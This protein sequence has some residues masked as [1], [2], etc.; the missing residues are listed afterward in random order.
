[1]IHPEDDRHEQVEEP[2]PPRDPDVNCS[3]G[4]GN[5][6]EDRAEEDAEPQCIEGSGLT[7]QEEVQRLRA[8]LARLAPRCPDVVL[9]D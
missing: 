2:Q 5:R 6:E 1:M 8:R 4:E 7:K 9:H 3:G